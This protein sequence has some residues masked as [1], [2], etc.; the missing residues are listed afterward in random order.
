MRLQHKPKSSKNSNTYNYF[1]KKR[2]NI[3]IGERRDEKI[4]YLVHT[5][6]KQI[7]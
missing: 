1:R 7:R 6:Q 5:L 3:Q 2:K 4:A